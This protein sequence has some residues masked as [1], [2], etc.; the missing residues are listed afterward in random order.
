MNEHEQRLRSFVYVR[1]CL[2]MC[3]FM[4]P[5]LYSFKGFYMLYFCLLFLVL[6][7]LKP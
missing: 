2:V 1:E 5:C 3:S 7:N 4:F 6:K